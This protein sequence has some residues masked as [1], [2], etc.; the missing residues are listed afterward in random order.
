MK[1]AVFLIVVVLVSLSGCGPS[2]SQVKADFV[3]MARRRGVLIS[4]EARANKMRRV[5]VDG[6]L[7]CQL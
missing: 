7:E 5:Q 2:E 6:S 3:R 1:T 4:G